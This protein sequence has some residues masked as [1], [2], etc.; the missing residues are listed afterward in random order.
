MLRASSVPCMSERK[1]KLLYCHEEQKDIVFSSC[2]SFE[3]CYIP[4]LPKVF[5]ILSNFFL[6]GSLFFHEPLDVKLWSA[7]YDY[8]GHTGLTMHWV[9]KQGHAHLTEWLDWSVINQ[10]FQELRHKQYDLL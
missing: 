3:M 2:K 7:S 10:E 4:R 6:N 1:G 5:T 9:N 8:G